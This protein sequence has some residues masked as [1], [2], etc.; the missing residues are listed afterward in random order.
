MN[1]SHALAAGISGIIFVAVYRLAV[2][3]S[4]SGQ[5]QIAVECATAYG[6]IASGE[7]GGFVQ[8]REETCGHAALAFFLTPATEASLIRETGT[9]SMLSLADM[10]MVFTKRGLKTQMLQVDPQYFK[11]HPAT[12][13]LHLSS[14]HFVV[15]LGVENGEPEL[16]DPAYGQVF[17]PWKTLL[18]LFSGYMS[19]GAFFPSAQGSFRFTGP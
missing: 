18:R 19:P 17:V 1:K 3:Y 10:D 5:P 13:I 15:F 6:G 9:D 12:A 2:G 7:W 16:F 11:Q 4:F 14:R 8:T